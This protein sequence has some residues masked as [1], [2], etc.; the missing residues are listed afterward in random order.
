MESVKTVKTFNARTSSSDFSNQLSQ[1]RVVMLMT[2]GK[3]RI[4]HTVTYVTQ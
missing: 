3:I 1:E 4:E 2:S